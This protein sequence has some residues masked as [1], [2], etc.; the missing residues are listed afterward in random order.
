MKTKLIL[1]LLCLTM[2]SGFSQNQDRRDRIK[3]L[4]IAF[5]TERLNLT[6][7]E[8]EK[9]WPIYNAFE[10]A[11]HQLRH[12]TRMER[13]DFDIENLTDAEANNILDAMLKSESEKLELRKKFL[14][15]LKSVLPAKKIILL[16][17]SEDQF[18]RRMLEEMRK[19]R[20]GYGN[21]RN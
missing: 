9:F 6:Q 12:E 13:A 19:R 10:D 3:T 11:N 14:Q 1:L 2:L 20:E 4:K 15:D 7:T 17:A 8:A 16:K 18:N 5:I 21:K